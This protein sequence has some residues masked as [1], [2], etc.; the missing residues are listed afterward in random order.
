MRASFVLLLGIATLPLVA[1]TGDDPALHRPAAVSPVAP[2]ASAVAPSTQ[3][4]VVASAV[5][6]LS[7]AWNWQGA[8]HLTVPAS[9]VQRLF[10]IEPE[11]P[12]THLR[13]EGAGTMQL[14]QSGTTFSGLA[15]RTFASCETGAGHVFVPPP[16]A[17]SNSLPVA[18]GLITGRA[19][20][21]LLGGVAGLGCPHNGS[22][23][24]VEAG[25]ATEIRA[26]GRCIIP[27]HPKSPVPRDP[28]PAGTSHDTSFVATRP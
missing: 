14:V 20:H 25:S 2:T 4:A 3:S 12:V 19:V 22:I 11:G 15:T 28:P 23:K 16:S 24:D 7:G 1:C 26:N 8:G 6:N 9:D 13:C 5:P 18:E 21:F 10:G 17:G 27:G